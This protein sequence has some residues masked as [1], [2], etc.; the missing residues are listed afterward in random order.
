MTQLVANEASAEASLSRSGT[1]KWHC[2][3]SQ[4]GSAFSATL[5]NTDAH[6]PPP[7][8]E[9]G[10]GEAAAKAGAEAEA[11]DVAAAG[12]VEVESALA[13]WLRSVDTEA[14]APSALCRWAHQSH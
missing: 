5:E 13:V 1:S 2:A 10:T 6:P 7:D 3:T 9:P 14:S 4:S 11:E 8:I 12:V